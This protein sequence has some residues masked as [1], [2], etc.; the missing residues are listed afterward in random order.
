MSFKTIEKAILDELRI[1]TQNSNFRQKDIMEW[2]TARL[3][4]KL[5]TGEMRVYLP[6]LHVHVIA[7]IPK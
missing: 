4:S 5:E 1:I 6:T 3:S 2:S 7:V